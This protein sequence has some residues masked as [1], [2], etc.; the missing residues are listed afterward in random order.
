MF[1]SIITTRKAYI[2]LLSSL[3]LILPVYAQKKVT[4]QQAID[5]TLK[6]NIQIRQAQFDEELSAEDLTIAKNSLY[7]TLNGSVDAYRLYGRSIDPVT[8]AYARSGSNYAQAGLYADVTIFQG[9]QKINTIKQ[10]R[11]LL[12]ARKSA[13]AKIKNDLTLSVLQDYLQLLS[14]RD[15]LTASKQQLKIAQEELDRQEKFYKV[16]QKTLAD[17]SQ[18]KAQA[19]AAQSNQTNAQNE[20][21]RAG[22]LLGQLMERRGNGSDFVA[23]DPPKDEIDNLNLRYN[24]IDVYIRS[25]K[26]YPDILLAE[27]NTLA[28]EK[29]V[30][31]AKGKQLPVLSVGGILNTSYSD[32]LRTVGTVVTGAVPVGITQTTGETV[33]APIYA[34]NTVGLKNQLQTNVNEAVG[35]T[36]TIPIL[37]GFAAHSNVKKAKI[38]YQNALAA[39]QLAKVNISKV[40]AE[41]VWDLQAT[42]KKF[43]SAQVSYKS[44][45]DAFT[46]IQQRYS[47]GL[48][49]S[50]DLNI[51]ET[52]KNLAE[53]AL[54][55]A[56]YDLIFKNKL[57]DYYL[58]NEIKF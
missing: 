26:A 18:A 50:L 24:A 10:N 52:Q 1:K 32:N 11:Y 41:A 48:V 58:G 15:L 34:T 13:L 43:K 57:I 12:D 9:F 39:E 56:K 38:Q 27:N 36:L 30:D 20:M 19:A 54:I 2:V 40:I 33:L 22:L 45:G 46:V 37:N 53:F 17:L 14:N 5:S 7:P 21:E 29:A 28:A 49:N 6:N 44:A 35:A 42:E 8:Y 23:V 3:V 47:V 4:L 31:V 51:A 25:L 55:Q 16:G